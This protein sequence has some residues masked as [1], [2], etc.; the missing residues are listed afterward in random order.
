MEKG[1]LELEIVDVGSCL[2]TKKLGERSRHWEVKLA[3]GK[4]LVSGG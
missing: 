3:S 2:G 4:G 1:E